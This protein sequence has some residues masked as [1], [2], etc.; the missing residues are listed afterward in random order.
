MTKLLEQLV[1]ISSPTGSESQIIAF[2]IEELNQHGLKANKQD[3]N[4]VVFI[5]GKNR[6]K[7]LILNGHVDTVGPGDADSWKFSPL[8]PKVKDGKLYGLGVSDMK[9]GVAALM[10]TAIDYSDKQPPCDLW[11][12]FVVG[13]EVDGRGTQSFLSWFYNEHHHEDYEEIEAIVAEPTNSEFIGIGHRGNA[14][15][16]LTVMG[17]S[18]HSSAA[19]KI[20]NQAIVEMTDVVARLQRLEKKWQKEYKH[21]Y[22]GV[23]TFGLTSMHS[24]SIDAPNKIPG[25]ATI[26][27]DIRTT[28]LLHEKINSLM[29]EFTTSLPYDSFFNFI[30]TSPA[31][32]CSENSILR[33]L[34]SKEWPQIRQQTMNGSADQCFFSQR[35][36]PAVI[37]GPGQRDRMHAPDEYFVVSRMKPYLQ[38]VKKIISAFGEV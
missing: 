5:K 23:P 30:G 15:V 27:I 33:S 26:T 19:N 21:D 28:P 14:F 13:E 34:F 29:R 2:I 16:E 36:I 22:L 8:M 38:Q 24:G 4:A 32:W 17:Q 10:Q 7:A 12:C 31:G 35:G 18:G 9:S 1:S 6:K 3:E 25:T 11:F 37:F 20:K